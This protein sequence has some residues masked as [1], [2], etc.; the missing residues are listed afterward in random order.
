LITSSY[1]Y[2]ADKGGAIK[3]TYEKLDTEANNFQL[4]ISGN[5]TKMVLFETIN[6]AKVVMHGSANLRSAQCAE[7]LTIEEGPEVYD[8]YLDFMDTI[9]AEFKTI[10]HNVPKQKLKELRHK[11][12]NDLI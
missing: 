4:V 8:F 1:L 11:K 9:I 6:G 10:N 3:Y 7:Q 5:H 12:L 2:G